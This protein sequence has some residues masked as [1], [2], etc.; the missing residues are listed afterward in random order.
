MLTKLRV[1]GFKNLLDA[2]IYF[3]P[4]TVIAGANGVGKSNIFD[5][6]HFLKLLTSKE[7]IEAAQSIRDENGRSGGIRGLFFRTSEEYVPTMKFEVQMITPQIGFDHLRQK[8]TATSTFLRYTL[9]I[10]Y[11]GEESPYGPLEILL[12]ELDYIKKSDAP[13]HI[14]FPHRSKGWRDSIH[15]ARRSTGRPYLRTD[16]E[17]GKRVIKIAQDGTAGR[18]AER[19]AEPLPRTVLSSLSAAESQTAVLARA[20]MASWRLLQFEPSALRRSDRFRD[21]SEV[22]ADGSHMAATLHRLVGNGART[23]PRDGEATRQHI[24]NR[25]AE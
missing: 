19:L 1:S 2:E 4:F 11:R 13:K 24:A 6:I 20:E 10:K 7:L 17:K 18:P 22:G 8:A 16:S 15:V 14:L 3:G 25:L 5:A 9:E 23:P 12:E 21:A